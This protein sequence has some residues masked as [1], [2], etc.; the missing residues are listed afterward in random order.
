M[1]KKKSAAVKAKT[2]HD[3]DKKI[4]DAPVSQAIVESSVVHDESSLYLFTL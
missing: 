2:R 3:A 4:K 1:A